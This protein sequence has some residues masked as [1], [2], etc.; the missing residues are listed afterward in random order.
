MADARDGM[1]YDYQR[2]EQEGRYFSM[3]EVTGG[4]LSSMFLPATIAANYKK[5]FPNTEHVFAIKITKASAEPTSVTR[6][7]GAV[8]PSGVKPKSQ[9]VLLDGDSMGEFMDVLPTFVNCV[10]PNLQAQVQGGD[11]EQL[12]EYSTFTVAPQVRASAVLKE[13][14]RNSKDKMALTAKVVQF[15]KSFS[16]QLSY[17]V[18]ANYGYSVYI[19]ETMRE[20]LLQEKGAIMRAVNRLSSGTA[21]K[22]FPLDMSACGRGDETRR[23][24]LESAGQDDPAMDNIMQHDDE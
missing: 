5:L 11:T 20:W 17:P 15:P 13:F 10:I 6:K 21:W 16:L 1:D 24:K 3:L 23:A 9:Y 7:G 8:F 14:N 22:S 18:E 4:E 19:N 2:A 12:S